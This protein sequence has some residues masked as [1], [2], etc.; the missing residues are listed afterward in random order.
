MR[1]DKDGTGIFDRRERHLAQE[2]SDSRDGPAAQKPS[3]DRSEGGR[4]R[5]LPF[6]LRLGTAAQE[7][8]Y[9]HRIDWAQR[10]A[11]TA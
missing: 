8:Q 9:A 11:Q 10:Y 2:L 3:P 6:F 7:R 1:N 4:D 5:V